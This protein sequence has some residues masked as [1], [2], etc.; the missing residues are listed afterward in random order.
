MNYQ[1]E[2]E[3]F[4]GREKTRPKQKW[5]EQ[6]LWVIIGHGANDV[7]IPA[8]IFK[9]KQ[10]ALDKIKEAGPLIMP[11]DNEL[12]FVLNGNGKLRQEEERACEK[13]YTRCYF[14]C[15][16]VYKIEVRK[17]KFGEKL[18]CFDLD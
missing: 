12:K 3:R 13:F 8:M 18:T 14:G 10:E 6:E 9:T 1:D 5:M 15:G 7:A 16:G 17:V 4:F 2:A 11:T